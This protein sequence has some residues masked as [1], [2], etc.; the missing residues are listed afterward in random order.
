VD[1]YSHI[2]LLLISFFLCKMSK[3]KVQSW[4]LRIKWDQICNILSTMPMPCTL[5]VMWPFL[6]RK[7]LCC[8][9]S[10]QSFPASRICLCYFAFYYCFSDPFLL[11]AIKLKLTWHAITKIFIIHLIKI[12]NNIGKRIS[13]YP[14][15]IFF[16]YFKCFSVK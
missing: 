6:D 7:F 13:S 4:F 11:N 5:S 3:A 14:E 1:F 8:L 12:L 15:Y 10:T 16:H 2:A 9:S